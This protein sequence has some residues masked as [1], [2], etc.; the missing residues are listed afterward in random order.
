MI[1]LHDRVTL[2]FL[3][4]QDTCFA[5]HWLG[6]P[7]FFVFTKGFFHLLGE[8]GGSYIRTLN[9]SWPQRPA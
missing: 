2:F 4:P 6:K 5:I 7:Y 1:A 8:K 3:R 9:K